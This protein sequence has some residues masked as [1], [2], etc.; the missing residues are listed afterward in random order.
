[1]EK[2]EQEIKSITHQMFGIKEEQINRESRLKEDLGLD[3]LDCIELVLEL[4]IQFDM[5]IPDEDAEDFRMVDD[6][7]KYIEK[8]KAKHSYERELRNK[9]LH[10]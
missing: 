5:S 1:M 8:S 4:E 9:H 10:R 3:S 2:I 6:V 7:I